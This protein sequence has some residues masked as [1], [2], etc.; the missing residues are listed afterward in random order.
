MNCVFMTPNGADRK[1]E[2]AS[3]AGQLSLYLKV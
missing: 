3:L 1:P 2:G